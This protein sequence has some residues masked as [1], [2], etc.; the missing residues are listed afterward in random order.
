MSLWRFS[1]TTVVGYLPLTALVAYLGSNARSLSLSD[2]LV[3]IAVAVAV[4]VLSAHWV[5]SRRQR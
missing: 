4:L 1:W 3:W 2:P 5:V